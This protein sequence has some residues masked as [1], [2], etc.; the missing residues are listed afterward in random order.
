M[1]VKRQL[2]VLD[3][4]L[5]QYPYIAGENYSIADMAIWPWYGGLV[6]KALYGAGEFLDVES[7]THVVKWADKIMN[8]PAVQ[9]GRRVN[10]V[11]G[12]EEEQLPER[13]SSADFLATK[14]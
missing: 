12:P 3:R 10:L 7:Y 2:D 6:R 14:P 5:T 8:R 1:E 13:H 9:R 4:Q 11:W